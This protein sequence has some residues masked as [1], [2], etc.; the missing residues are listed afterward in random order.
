MLLNYDHHKVGGLNRISMPL[1]L[2]ILVRISDKKN[3]KSSILASKD[4]QRKV[5]A[6]VLM[7]FKGLYLI[8]KVLQRLSIKRLRAEVAGNKQKTEALI[9]LRA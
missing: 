2:H 7:D 9:A 4:A 1:F 5:I 6:S 8:I 3:F